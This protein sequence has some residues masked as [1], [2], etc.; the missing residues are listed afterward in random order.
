VLPVI[1]LRWLGHATVVVDLGGV[2]LLTDP[3]LRPH[4][5]LLRRIGPVPREEDWTGADAVLLSHLHSDHA[6]LS[7]LRMLP[8]PPLLSG[9]LNAPWLSKRLANPV[10]PMTDGEWVTVP[11]RRRNEKVDVGAVRADHSHRPMPHRPN[12]THGFLLRGSAGVVYFA[13]DTSLYD[14]MADLPAQAGAPVDVALMPIAGWGPRL[15]AGHMG[16]AQ[17]AEAC[18]LMGARAA[19]PIHHGT[20]HPTGHHLIGLDWMHRPAERFARDLARLAPDC[21]LL[22]LSLGES[23]ELP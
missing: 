4:A 21:R 7:S 19:V 18:R 12:D 2:R 17:A 22:G 6:S 1:R 3:L 16:P 23:V 10:V 13:G 8:D 5:G 20:L 11:D 14:E 15:S 9:T